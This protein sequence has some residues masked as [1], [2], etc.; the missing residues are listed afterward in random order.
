MKRSIIVAALLGISSAL[1]ALASEQSPAQ[2]GD[3]RPVA[4]DDQQLDAVRGGDLLGLNLSSLGAT[5]GTVTGTL[6]GTVNG[7]TSGLLGSGT[8]AVAGSGGLLGSGGG[9]LQPVN[10]LLN[11]ANGLLGNLGL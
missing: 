8:G 2:A 9:L 5:L 10:N 7:L 11:T 3:H 1:P 4:L 6:T